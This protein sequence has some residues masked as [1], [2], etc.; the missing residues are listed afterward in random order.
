MYGT[1]EV[2]PPSCWPLIPWQ[3][4]GAKEACCLDSSVTGYWGC[5]L[6]TFSFVWKPAIEIRIKEQGLLLLIIIL[7]SYKMGLDPA[8]EDVQSTGYNLEIGE[9]EGG[10]ERKSD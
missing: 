4:V 3:R 5:S 6:L 7:S 10:W 9:R 8:C 2:R 1:E